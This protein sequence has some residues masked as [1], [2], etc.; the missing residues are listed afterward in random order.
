MTTK[1]SKKM[2]LKARKKDT[3]PGAVQQKVAGQ[4]P[5]DKPN[6]TKSQ[7]ALLDTICEEGEENFSEA[8]RHRRPLDLL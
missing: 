1:R 6:A 5:Q 7:E 2:S 4:E 3:D 8:E